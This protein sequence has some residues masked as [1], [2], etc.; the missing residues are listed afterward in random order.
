MLRNPSSANNIN[1]P[2]IS[3]TASTTSA[4]NNTGTTCRPRIPTERAPTARAASMYSFGLTPITCPL[5]NCATSPHP[6]THSATTNTHI[7][8]CIPNPC[9]TI[10]ANSVTGNAAHTPT[11]PLTNRSTQ[12]PSHHPAAIPNTVPTTTLA[13]IPNNANASVCLAPAN[14]NALRSRPT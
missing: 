7:P 8:C 2:P 6:T 10:I 11:A 3:N 14:T 13:T 1:T 9:I 5:T 4:G 12:L